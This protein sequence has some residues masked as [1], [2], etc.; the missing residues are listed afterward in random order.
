VANIFKTGFIAL[1]TEEILAHTP[2]I[3]YAGE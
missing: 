3:K 2:D 1:L